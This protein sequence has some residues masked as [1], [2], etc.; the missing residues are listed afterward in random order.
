MQHPTDGV[1]I[2]A[3][4]EIELKVEI[5][6]REFARC[7]LQERLHQLTDGHDRGSPRTDAA[8]TLCASRMRRS[9]WMNA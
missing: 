4:E 6:A 8:R 5:K 3:R 9:T 7:R 2:P 1:P